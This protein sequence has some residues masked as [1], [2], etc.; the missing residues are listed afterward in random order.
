MQAQ[1]CVAP[2]AGWPRASALLQ[3]RAVLIPS[4]LAHP[5]P[6]CLP[7]LVPGEGDPVTRPLKVEEGLLLSVLEAAANKGHVPL[8]EDA[9]RLLERS[10]ALPNPPGSLGALGTH[11]GSAARLEEE[12]AEEAG[13]DAL[14]AADAE[15]AGEGEAVPAVPQDQ[16]DAELESAH[17]RAAEAAEAAAEQQQQ[18]G[19]GGGG[20]RREAPPSESPDWGE[21]AREEVRALA[22]QGRGTRAPSLL[23]HLALVHAYARAGEF[24]SMFRAVARVEEVGGKLLAPLALLRRLRVQ[25]MVRPC[26]PACPR[27]AAA[28]PATP[29]LAA[30][31][32]PGSLP[33]G[34]DL[35][36][37]PEDAAAAAYH[38]GLPMCVDALAAS[39]A[40]CDEAFALLESWAKE[41]SAPPGHGLRA[42]SWLLGGVL[43]DPAA[44]SRAEWAWRIAVGRR[45][46]AAW[47]L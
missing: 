27:L 31:K 46:R 43:C 21:L 3:S 47:L 9:W 29:Q 5:P 28:L 2:E 18:Q 39:L 37:F 12:A 6:A 23:S 22:A 13:P 19:G 36:A 35:Q 17:L 26:F 40:G 38:T 44:P 32:L 16:L 8:A 11:P 10:V 4:A 7:Q 34:S 30:S 14:L 24:G 42:L 33:L 45:D 1:L 41:A 25:G 20:R 15:A